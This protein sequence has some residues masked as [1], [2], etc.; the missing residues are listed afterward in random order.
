MKRLWWWLTFSRW[1]AGTDDAFDAVLECLDVLDRHI[2][3]GTHAFQ[4]TTG[5]R[6]TIKQ[7]KD[8]T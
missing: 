4:M 7:M 1:K 5:L 8:G 3:E 6:F 2:P